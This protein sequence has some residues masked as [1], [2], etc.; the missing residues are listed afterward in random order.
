VTDPD[1]QPELSNEARIRR[2]PR[3]GRF[4]FVGGAV[5]LIGTLILTSL[6][7]ADPAVG[8]PA[9]FGYFALYGVPI[10]VALGALLA[11]VLDRVS[12]NRSKTVLVAH[13][14]VE[15]E[16][17]TDQAPSATESVERGPDSGSARDIG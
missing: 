12:L 6:Y 11:L 3:L 17:S 15:R 4:L 8:F 5:G 1:P 16:V 14:H 13:E 2:A 10:G 9:L 7:P